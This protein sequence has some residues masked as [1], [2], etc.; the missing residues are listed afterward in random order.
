MKGFINIVS[1]FINIVNCMYLF[2]SVQHD[3]YLI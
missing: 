1:Q 2:G 3:K